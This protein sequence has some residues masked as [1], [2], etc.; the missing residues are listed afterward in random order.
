[1]KSIAPLLTILLCLFTHPASAA[2]RVTQVE[3]DAELMPA[4]N[5]DSTVALVGGETVNPE[6]RVVTGMDSTVSLTFDDSSVVVVKELTDVK[7]G[8]YQSGGD[9]VRTRLWLKAGEV[10]AEVNP[11][12]TTRSD[13][14]VKTPTATCSVR[15]TGLDVGYS[16]GNGRTLQRTRHGNVLFQAFSGQSTSNSA[17]Q[18]SQ[19][20]DKDL[21]TDADVKTGEATSTSLPGGTSQDEKDGV[22]ESGNLLTNTGAG[23]PGDV[24]STG[25]SNST[26][27]GIA[28]EA[29]D[30]SPEPETPEVDQDDGIP[31]FFKIIALQGDQAPDENGDP[32]VGSFTLFGTPAFDS[33]DGNG[34][35]VFAASTSLDPCDPSRPYGVFMATGEKFEALA[36][37]GYQHADSKV[38]TT[39]IFHND[40]SSFVDVEG[41]HAAF[42]GR[43]NFFDGAISVP[44]EALFIS[45]AEGDPITVADTRDAGTTGGIQFL[46]MQAPG[47]LKSSG[48]IFSLAENEVDGTFEVAFTASMNNGDGETDTI[49]IGD[50]DMLMSIGVNEFDSVVT[51]NS[52]TNEFLG[53]S[54][55]APFPTA[56]RE[57]SYSIGQEAGTGEA[58]RQVSFIGHFSGPSGGEGVFVRDVNNAQTIAIADTGTAI[59]DHPSAGVPFGSFSGTA[60]EGSTLAFIGNDPGTAFDFQG[61]Y[62]VD[63][64]HAGAFTLDTVVNTETLFDVGHPLA[65]RRFDFFDSIALEEGLVTFSGGHVDAMEPGS[66]VRGLFRETATGEILPIVQ[67]GDVFSGTLAGSSEP[68]EVIIADVVAGPNSSDGLVSSAQITVEIP[69]PVDGGDGG[70]SLGP[71]DGT[72]ID[73]I[74]IGT[75]ASAGAAP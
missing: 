38:P 6:D 58:H 9:M 18:E 44:Y 72:F 28:D 73:A 50:G 19:A 59:P 4:G 51:A 55:D 21:E 65:G 67:Q 66:P 64:I 12:K 15:G 75:G 5:A 32:N 43:A 8:E 46:N 47:G 35:I 17:G 24:G 29:S 61:I 63:D 48:S 40:F 39:Q 13:F 49:F 56:F 16:P 23:A 68:Q 27:S 60:L 1:M 31:D 30:T 62:R 70:Q 69:P 53:P 37:R 54:G 42:M 20:D 10:S 52:G 74:V 14:A 33:N 26:V 45:N 34:T 3:G 7:I 22:E 41:D 2:I 71:R 25:S 57:V 11:E 36:Y